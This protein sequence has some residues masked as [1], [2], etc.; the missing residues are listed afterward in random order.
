MELIIK[1]GELEDQVSIARH[2][3]GYAVRVGERAYLVDAVAVGPGRRSLLL[4]GEQVEVSVR[5]L[6]DGALWVRSRHGEGVVEVSDP[7]THLARASR[8]G[9][10]PQ[11]RRV[12]KAY[13][14]GR[15]VA[16]LASEGD[17]LTAGQGVVVLEAMKMENEIKTD[18]PGTLVKLHVTEGQ[19]VEGGDVLFEVE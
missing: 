15:V 14:P 10:G 11:G 13:M 6:A 18:H 5:E 8:G 4:D 12:V 3:D 7:L 2:G 19:A 17:S 1:D 9:T 16:L